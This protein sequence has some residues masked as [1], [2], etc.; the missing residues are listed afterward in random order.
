M[1]S[2]NFEKAV[3]QF[4]DFIVE[5]GLDEYEVHFVSEIKSLQRVEFISYLCE[6][7]AKAENATDKKEKKPI[8]KKPV[9]KKDEFNRG[10]SVSMESVIRDVEPELERQKHE[11]MVLE[12]E[13]EVIINSLISNRDQRT[14]LEDTIST[15]EVKVSELYRKFPEVSRPNELNT[16]KDEYFS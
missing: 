10:I 2:F 4:P 12:D 6:L 3:E 11:R 1:N 15:L 14:V 7:V 13:K 16:D 8:D 9:F 5:K